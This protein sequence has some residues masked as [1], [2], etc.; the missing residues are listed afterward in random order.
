M[1]GSAE[2]SGVIMLSMSAV[3]SVV[4]V[5][6][7]WPDMSGRHSTPAARPPA[8]TATPTPTP[9]SSEPPPTP[10]PRPKPTA[11]TPSPSATHPKDG[12]PLAGDIS[13]AV[14]Q[15]ALEQSRQANV[16]P[17]LEKR[18]VDLGGKVLLADVTGKSRK[19]YPDYFKGQPATD[20]WLKCH[21]RAGVAERYENRS[22]AVLVHL[23][24]AGTSPEGERDERRPATVLLVRDVNGKWAPRPL[25]EE[26][27]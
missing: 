23:V 5:V 13:D 26:E 16:P 1:S 6:L 25:S 21:I 19:E 14:L 24:W 15:H 7:L 4:G 3:L 18:L 10:K 2:R 17:T 8:A 22:D 27:G 11:S 9:T 20:I 12:D